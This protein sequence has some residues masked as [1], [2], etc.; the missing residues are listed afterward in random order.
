MRSAVRRPVCALIIEST[1]AGS[2][3]LGEN[4]SV[5]L[6]E[7]RGVEEE[8]EWLEKNLPNWN[9]E[10]HRLTLDTVPDDT[11]FKLELQKLL[12]QEWSLVHYIGHCHLDEQ[13][14]KRYIFCPGYPPEAIEIGVFA[15]W[16]VEAKT[17]FLFLSGCRSSEAGFVFKLAQQQ[18]PAVLGFY[19]AIS[20][21]DAP[22]FTELFYQS[23]FDSTDGRCIERAFLSA[24]KAMREVERDRPKMQRSGFWAAPLLIMQTSN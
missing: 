17:R 24:R 12:K 11:S 7:L 21:D 20:D 10:V 16:L 6:P 5:T 22:K 15:N 4:Q 3:E 8:A 2:I 23:L 18:I 19:R 14:S 13:S 1:A 9:G